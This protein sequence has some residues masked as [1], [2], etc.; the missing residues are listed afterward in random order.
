MEYS[1]QQRQ[2]YIDIELDMLIDNFLQRIARAIL[3]SRG[4]ED[5]LGMD[6]LIDNMISRRIQDLLDL[7]Y[8]EHNLQ[9]LVSRYMD[10]VHNA[11]YDSLSQAEQYLVDDHIMS[12]TASMMRISH[13]RNEDENMFLITQIRQQH[14]AG[15][16]QNGVMLPHEDPQIGYA[17]QQGANYPVRYIPKTQQEECMC[18]ICFLTAKNTSDPQN[19][20]NM[21]IIRPCGHCFHLNC[22]S[23]WLR[24]ASRCPNCRTGVEEMVVFYRDPTSLRRSSLRSARTSRKRFSTRMSG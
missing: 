13:A 20:E 1:A 19:E 12:L 18:S 5:E 23:T 17:P 4:I 3:V 2:N 11:N 22:I 15:L 7:G 16:L 21:A 6:G 24:G 14:N 8:P 9:N 10:A